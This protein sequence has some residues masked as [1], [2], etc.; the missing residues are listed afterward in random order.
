MI[1][2]NS[3]HQTKK[4][5]T[6]L[7]DSDETINSTHGAQEDNNNT[8]NEIKLF[9]INDDSGSNPPDKLVHLRWTNWMPIEKGKAR[10]DSGISEKPY[11]EFTTII[12]GFV[13]AKVK[14]R[15]SIT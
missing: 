10:P 2:T 11:L 5:R 15:S 8:N 7:E 6:A 12:I 9:I 4:V 1:E 14:Q 13:E 3:V